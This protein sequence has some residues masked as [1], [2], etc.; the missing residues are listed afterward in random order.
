MH[1][2]RKYEEAGGIDL[3]FGGNDLPNRYTRAFVLHKGIEG[4]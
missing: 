1:L 4:V 2:K 3:Y